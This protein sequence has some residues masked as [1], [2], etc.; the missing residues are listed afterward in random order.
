MKTAREKARAKG[1]KL[2][3]GKPCSKCGS[4]ERRVSNGNCNPCIMRRMATA[5]SRKLQRDARLRRKAAIRAGTWE[6]PRRSKQNATRSVAR[7][8]AEG[9]NGMRG[10]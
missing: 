9:N 7:L 3:K 8:M 5:D 1:L 10:T 2:Y 6:F 4:Q